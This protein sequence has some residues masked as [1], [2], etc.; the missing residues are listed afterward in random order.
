MRDLGFRSW[1]AESCRWEAGLGQ[2]RLCSR[3]YV[4]ACQIQG[5]GRLRSG[6]RSRRWAQGQQWQCL[7]GAV[8]C[9]GVECCV[10]QC[11]AGRL[12][13]QPVTATPVQK[14]GRWERSRGVT[15]AKTRHVA[16]CNISGCKPYKSEQGREG[17][18]GA[19]GTRPAWRSLGDKSLQCQIRLS[20]LTSIQRNFNIE[21]APQTRQ[22]LY[23]STLE[24][25]LPL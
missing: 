15:S 1:P 4:G 23:L 12:G 21:E 16:G 11:C 13:S 8:G 10:E 2:E 19:E 5:S 25:R 7:R 14:V 17:Q 6:R 9:S 24:P 20:S 22:P 18:G 3:G